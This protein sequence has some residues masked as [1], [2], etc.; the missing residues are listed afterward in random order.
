MALSD[1]KP[2]PRIRFNGSMTTNMRSLSTR[3]PS[4]VLVLPSFALPAAR[5]LAHPGRQQFPA[6]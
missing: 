3:V 2:L 6:A 1:Y 4:P 5:V